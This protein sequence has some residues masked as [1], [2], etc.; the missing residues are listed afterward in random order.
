MHIILVL[1]RWSSLIFISIFIVF[2]MIYFETEWLCSVS[3]QDG[4]HK[5]SFSTW[6]KQDRVDMFRTDPTI[7]LIMLLYRS[8]ITTFIPLANPI[9]LMLKPINPLENQLLDRFDPLRLKLRHSIHFHDDPLRIIWLLI[10]TVQSI[11]NILN[12]FESVCIFVG[13]HS[14]SPRQKV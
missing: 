7:V 14:Y 5:E 2:N 1:L 12:S 3:W 6:P 11:T 8:L 10:T 4:P 13:S 9:L